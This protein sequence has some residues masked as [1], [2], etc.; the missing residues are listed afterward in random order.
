MSGGFIH[1][2]M[3]LSTEQIKAAEP[4]SIPA[5]ACDAFLEDTDWHRLQSKSNKLAC[6]SAG[7]QD[8][9]VATTMLMPPDLH[10][11]L[12]SPISSCTAS[13]ASTAPLSRPQFRLVFRPQILLNAPISTCQTPTSP[14]SSD[15]SFE[16]TLFKV[17]FS[18]F[19][20][21]WSLLAD[22]ICP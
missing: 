22:S 21:V 15:R 19:V 8:F 16:S 13:V 7:S 17:Y 10:P 14:R 11:I 5:T 12:S 18:I 9:R 2:L 4:T 1:E 20:F 6:E 3:R